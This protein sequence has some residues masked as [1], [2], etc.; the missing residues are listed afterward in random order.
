MENKIP[1]AAF[2]LKNIRFTKASLDFEFAPKGEGLN[3][4]FN[5]SGNYINEKKIFY[6]SIEFNAFEE[7]EEK[8]EKRNSY[9]STTVV[10]EFVFKNVNSLEEI[11]HFFYSNSIAILYPYIRAFVSN[12]SFQANVG[13]LILPTLNLSMLE[14]TLK[15]NTKSI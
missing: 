8:E 7:K 13:P 4:N 14:N 15:K 2:S 12:I 10:A 6:L 5:P 11:P 3:I 1:S 9:I